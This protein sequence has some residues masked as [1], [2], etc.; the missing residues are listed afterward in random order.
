VKCFGGKNKFVVPPKVFGCTCFVRDHRP[1]VGKLD[2]RAVKCIFVGYSI[3]QKG[4]KCWS[5][6]ERHLFVS[7]DV[8]C[9]ESVPFYGERTDLSFMFE[10]HST[11]IDEV[12]RE[13]GYGDVNASNEQQ[14]R[15]MDAVISGS[16]PQQKRVELMT[17]ST[18]SQ[19]DERVGN[20]KIYH[21]CI[22]GKKWISNT[23]YEGG[24]CIKYGTKSFI[25]S[26]S[27]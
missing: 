27:R 10:P 25:L 15:K 3:G 9:R 6:S 11:S 16:V 19:L 17:D 22:Q 1:S 21:K 24:S 2:P 4:Y 8:T 5:P 18:S 23:S 13:G 12:G 7:M 20:T 14:L 26:P